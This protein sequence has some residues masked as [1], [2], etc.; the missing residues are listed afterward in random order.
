MF[1]KPWRFL[2]ATAG[3]EETPGFCLRNQWRSREF[4]C[5]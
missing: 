1:F 2:S 5:D 3:P 4:G